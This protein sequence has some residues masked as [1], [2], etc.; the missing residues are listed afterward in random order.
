MK[1]GEQGVG[2][3]REFAGS[4]LGD[5]RRHN[6]LRQ[7]AE[8]LEADPSASLPKATRTDAALEAAYRFLGNEAVTMDSILA[9]HYAQTAE[10][11]ASERCVL[12]VHDTTEFRFSG[13]GSREGLGPLRGHGQGF[14]AHFALLLAPGELR[15]PLGVIALQTIVRPVGGRKSRPTV[16]GST[17]ESGRWKRSAELTEERLGDRCEVVHVMDREGDSYDLWA[18]LYNAGRRFVIR[19]WRSRRTANG[20]KLMDVLAA[21]KTVVER[22]VMLS[23]RKQEKIAFNRKRHPAREVRLARLALSAQRVTI[24]R[25]PGCSSELPETLSLNFVQVREVETNGD[26]PPVDWLLATTESIE[27]IQDIERIVDTYR[28]RWTIEEFFKA[29]KTG[30]AFE[31][32]QL[33]SVHTLQNALAVLVPIAWRLL[34]LRSL[35]RDH[36]DAPATEALTSVQVEVLIATSP[37][38]LPQTPTV[39]EVL[40]AVA[41]LGGHIKNNGEPGWMVIGRGVETLLTL[42]RG[43]KARERSDQS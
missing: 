9:G 33:E 15:R 27:T 34:L 11:A 42:E 32:R 43:W 31:K 28:A 8:A 19:H 22:E 10:R 4:T 23:R 5:V 12:A 17:Q 36:G 3:G 14:F 30:C 13:E 38:R 6:R 21:S 35:A 40:L 18:E 24:Q 25:A 20:L 41:A 37:T 26:E 7:L 1:Q 16:T 2:L 39:R 29:L